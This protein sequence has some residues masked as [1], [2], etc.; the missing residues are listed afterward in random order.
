MMRLGSGYTIN[1]P[2]NFSK[3]NFFKQQYIVKTFEFA[4]NMSFGGQGEHRSH[5]SG[6]NHSRKNGEIFINAFQGKLAEF[7]TYGIFALNGI[8]TS[9]PDLETYDLGIWDKCDLQINE[10]KIAIKSTKFFGNLLLLETSDWNNKGEYIPNIDIGESFY[11][12]FILVRIHPNGEDIMRNNHLIYNNEIDK[13]FLKEII[14]K[15]KWYFDCPGFIT[16]NELV[17]AINDKFVLPKGAML[18]GNKKMDAENYYIQSG[19]MHDM[20]EIFKLFK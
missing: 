2:K 18:N 9:V 15:E 7:A 19:D 5:R 13:T 10:K 16:H 14:T 3:T 4:Y 11:D 17:Q 20:N 12:F 8:K 6:G 1:N